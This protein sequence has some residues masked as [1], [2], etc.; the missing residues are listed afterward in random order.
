MPRCGNFFATSGV[1]DATFTALGADT[2]S[3]VYPVYKYLIRR[4]C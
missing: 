2:R 3:I 1:F 4:A